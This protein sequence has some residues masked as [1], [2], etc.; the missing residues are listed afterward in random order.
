MEII[1][2]NETE[3]NEDLAS[4]NRQRSIEE[5]RSFV[6]KRMAIVQDVEL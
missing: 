6:A 5:M 3:M 4:W 1:K 2:Q